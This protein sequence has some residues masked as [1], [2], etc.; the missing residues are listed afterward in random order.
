MPRTQG[1]SLSRY[2]TLPMRGGTKTYVSPGESTP[3]SKLDWSSD[4][5]WMSSLLP[6]TNV[7]GVSTRIRTGVGSN[8][9]LSPSAAKRIMSVAT[10]LAVGAAG[11]LDDCVPVPDDW[12]PVALA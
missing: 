9:Q 12:V 11:R 1:C 7:I 5:I 2:G 3:V 10:P 6:L 8:A 4:T